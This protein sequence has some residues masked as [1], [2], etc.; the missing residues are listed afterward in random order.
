MLANTYKS[1]LFPTLGKFQTVLNFGA[2]TSAPRS[3]EGT[4]IKF[5]L[6]GSGSM[7]DQSNEKAQGNKSDLATELIRTVVKAF[8]ENSYEISVFNDVVL[9]QKFNVDSVPKP[10]GCTY[11]TPI[12]PVLEKDLKESK[13]CAVVFLSDGLPSESLDVAQDAITAMGR[14]TREFNANPVAVA[15]GMDADG[16]SCAKFAGSR[17]YNCFF[18]YTEDLKQTSEDVINGIKCNYHMLSNGEFVPVE[19]DNHFYYVG[20]ASSASAETVKP[21]RHLVEKYLNLVLQKHINDIKNVPLLKSLVEH[22]VLLLDNEVEKAEVTKKYFDMLDKV[23]Q[24]IAALPPRAPAFLSAAS[25]AMRTASNQ[26]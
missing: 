6:D 20:D 19:A 1:V 17:G 24:I 22:C 9:D 13:H 12:P 5:F 16:V 15:V 14:I 3:I 4:K 7:S 10:S 26:V 8:P 25:S 23:K 21:T 11:F 2:N 18:K